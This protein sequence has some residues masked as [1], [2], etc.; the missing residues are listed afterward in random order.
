MNHLDSE[1]KSCTARFTFIGSH[2]VPLAQTTMPVNRTKCVHL[3]GVKAK[4]YCEITLVSTAAEVV[5]A[6]IHKAPFDGPKGI[7]CVDL[8]SYARG[9]AKIQARV[10]EETV[11][12]I[13]VEIVTISAVMLP[14]SRGESEVRSVSVDENNHVFAHRVPSSE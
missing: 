3:V 14:I 10:G 5:S 13:D 12:S 7:W 1:L 2:S 4:S 6:S 11:A 9:K 8:K